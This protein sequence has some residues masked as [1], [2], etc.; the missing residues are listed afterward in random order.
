MTTHRTPQPRTLEHLR[1]SPYHRELGRKLCAAF[2]A[3]QQGIHMNTA[4]KKVEDPVGDF[5]L[6]LAET[7]RDGWAKESLRDSPAVELFQ[8]DDGTVQ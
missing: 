5:W 3:Q 6:Q 4:L 7:V 2:V 1:R 8:S